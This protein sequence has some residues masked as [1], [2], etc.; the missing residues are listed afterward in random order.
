MCMQNIDFFQ[1]YEALIKNYLKQTFSEEIIFLYSYTEVA[2]T[3]L[4]GNAISFTHSHSI[5]RPHTP[6]CSRFLIQ[7]RSFIS[8]HCASLSIIQ[9]ILVLIQD[10][11]VAVHILPSFS[12]GVG[13]ERVTLAPS[14]N[15][16]HCP[17]SL[18]TDKGCVM[19]SRQ[20]TVM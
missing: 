7:L 20:L 4:Y 19:H 12:V 16:T 9:L 13:V 15:F 2:M 6:I 18:R 5:F 10:A 11:A 3:S 17:V 14:I 1:I 8:I